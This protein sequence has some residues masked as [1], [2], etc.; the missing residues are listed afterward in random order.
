[1]ELYHYEDEEIK[2]EIL[3]KSK[4]NEEEIELKQID[5]SNI[6]MFLKK[7]IFIITGYLRGEDE[8]NLTEIMKLNK[9]SMITGTS[10]ESLRDIEIKISRN[11]YV[12]RHLIFEGYLSSYNETYDNTKGYRFH[13]ILREHRQIN[14]DGAYIRTVTLKGVKGDMIIIPHDFNFNQTLLSALNGTTGYFM[15]GNATSA[16]SGGVTLGTGFLVFFFIAHGTGLVSE[17][18]ADVTFRIQ[19]KPEKMGSF[20]MTRDWFYKPL[21]ESIAENINSYVSNFKIDNNIGIEMYNCANLAFTLMSLESSLKT[22]VRKLRGYEGAG[23]Y[24]EVK[25]KNVAVS[26]WGRQSMSYRKYGSTTLKALIGDLTNIIPDTYT[27]KKAIET[28]MEKR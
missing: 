14:R 20:N 19:G 16:I 6:K 23:I 11:G 8:K 2:T 12:L 24:Y 17:F 21:G 7:G 15:L 13:F 1:M 9:W 10:K 25:Y 18:I 22:I 27:T 4:I 5:F 3:I 28:E 26:T